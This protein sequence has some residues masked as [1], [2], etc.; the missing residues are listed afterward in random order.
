MA[1][2]TGAG[3]GQP[4]TITT[5][6]TEIDKKLGGGIPIGSLVLLEGQSDAGKSV[7]TQHFCHQSLVTRMS[8]A[9]YTT[10]K[11]VKIQISKMKSLK[12]FH[13]T[14][15]VKLL[16]VIYVVKSSISISL[17]TFKTIMNFIEISNPKS[18]FVE[19]KND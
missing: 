17:V 7:L 6:S 4:T 16:L 19:R 5:G 10:E 1:G 9:N 3:V 8:V 12:L 2:S 11:T 14:K 15:H 18:L 13:L